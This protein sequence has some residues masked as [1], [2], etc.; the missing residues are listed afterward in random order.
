MRLLQ[1]TLM[2]CVALASPLV[3][4][5]KDIVD[6]A[7][8]AGSFKTLVA[9]VQAAGLVD[10]LKSKGPFTVFAPTDEAFSKLPNGTVESLLKPENKDQLVAILTYHVVAGQVKAAQVVEL[11]G[12]TTVNGQRVDIAVS[13]GKVS[14]D[15]ATVVATDIECS[16]G[17]VH[18]IDQVILPSSDNIPAVA[19]KAGG[20]K[21]LIAAA[22]A[23]GLVEA[24]SGKGPLTVFAPT[25]AAFAKLPKGTVETLLKPENKEQL[26]NILKYHVVSGRVYSTDAVKAG[27]AKTLLGQKIKI[28]VKDGKAMVN[29]SHLVALDIDASN[30]VIH[31]IDSVLLPAKP[32]KVGAVNGRQTIEHAVAKGHRLFNGGHHSACAEVYMTAMAGIVGSGQ[33]I[34]AHVMRDLKMTMVQAKQT[35]CPTERS[36]TL[37][38][39]LDRAYASMRALK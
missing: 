31:V 26:A 14:V 22:K 29:G 20:F 3:A 18:V 8:K 28:Q 35:H 7:V 6:T 27:S 4:A 39:G 36:W 5:E 38:H 9:A 12:A 10:T 23:A 11:T 24:I 25:D 37:R 34:N 19:T 32:K 17:V 33:P 21:T 1:A 13:E 30:G 16:N 15:G 2:T